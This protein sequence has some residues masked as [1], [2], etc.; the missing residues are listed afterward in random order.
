MV[1]CRRLRRH[2]SSSSSN[3]AFSLLRVKLGE[4]DFNGT[5]FGRW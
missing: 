5:V 2:R 3:D 4:L 1:G